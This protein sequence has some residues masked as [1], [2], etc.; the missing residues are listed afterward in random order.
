MSTIVRTRIVKI[1]NSQGIRIPKLLLDQTRLAGEVE[2]EP[3]GGQLVVRP[4]HPARH[5]WDTAFR[6]MAERADDELLDADLLPPSS[7]DEEEWEWS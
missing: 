1:G 5:G 6:A 2:L 3:Q 7:W 4:A